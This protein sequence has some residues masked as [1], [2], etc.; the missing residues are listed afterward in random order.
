MSKVLQIDRETLRKLQ[1][2]EL[3]SL[4]YFDSFCKEN[5]LRYYLLGGCVI[6]ALRHGGFIPWDDDIDIIMPRRDYERM[7]RLWKQQ[8]NNERFLML[9]TDGR[10]FTGNSF[11]TLIDTSATMIKENQK[12]IDV[13]HGI[14]TDI[15]PMDGCPDK[16]LQRYMQY[17]HAMMYSL[18]ITEFVPEKHGKLMKFICSL[19][20]KLFPSREKRTKIWKKHEKKMTKYG[21]NTHK[22][23]TELCA[24]PHY[25]LNEYPQKAFAKA[26]Y[27]D[28]EGMSVPLPQGY[29]EYLTMAFGDYMQMPPEDKQTPHHDLVTLDLD[30]PCINRDQ[31]I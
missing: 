27:H 14:V 5:E 26:V 3:E 24:G 4:E 23:C 13:P 8:E 18:F 30:T 11:A 12:D 28:F 2:K 10:V 9:K 7:L 31:P 25:M 19:L 1:L 21:F 29:D 17:Y 20:L 22:K 16:K 6:G 15:F